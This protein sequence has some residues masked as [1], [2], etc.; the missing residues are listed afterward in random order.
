M[1]AG[2]GGASGRDVADH[3]RAT[4]DGPSLMT[5]R[6]AAITGIFLIVLAAALKFASALLIPV[7]LAL[8]FNLLLSPLVRWLTLLR[9]PRALAALGVVGAV[10]GLLAMLVLNLYQPAIEWAERAPGFAFSVRDK[11]TPIREPVEQIGKMAKEVESLTDVTDDGDATQVEIAEPGIVDGLTDRLPVLAASTVV[12]QF[13]TFFML[14]AGESTMRKLAKLGRT[15]GERRRFV[16]IVTSVRSEV[17]RYLA[18][19][20]MINFVLGV[21]VFA[22]L[23]AQGVPNAALWG[24]LAMLA[25]YAPY[26]GATLMFFLLGLVGLISQPDVST[27][28]LVPASFLVLTIL[29]GQLLT[30]LIL[31]QRLGLSPVV[32]F[33]SVLFWGYLWGVAGALVA[34][35][36]AAAIR[37]A[38]SHMERGRALYIMLGR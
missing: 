27:A 25:N 28:L 18:T 24:V 13:L 11:L 21:A 12:V 34:V 15:F 3:D 19:I 22:V 29:E 6:S 35:P 1:S 20:T 7:A 36:I 17:T 2:T 5:I 9:I 10:T 33:L 26:V 16:A 4:L 8:F 14:A 37:M 30:P 31:G 23:R 38:A 32:I